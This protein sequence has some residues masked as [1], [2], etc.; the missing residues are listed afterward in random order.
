MDSRPIGVFDSGMGGLTS[1]APIMKK[2]PDEQI[3][4]YGDTARAPYGSKSPETVCDFTCQIAD[5]LVS[6]GTKMLVIAC[7]TI[8]A[9][10]IPRLAE[11][12]P[13][14]PVVGIIKPAAEYIATTCTPS[15][16]IGIIGTKVTVQSNAYP[17]A[18]SAYASGINI[19][20]LA[21]P[22]FVPLIEE[23]IIENEIMDLTIKHY[24]DSF[25]SKYNINKLVL[26]CTHYDFIKG[27]IRRLYPEL[28]IINPSEIVAQATLDALTA[29]DLLA[30]ERGGENI[31][32]AS[33]LSENFINFIAHITGTSD[34]KTALHKF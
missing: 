27:N 33:D 30:Q 8:S 6:K 11:S 10:A 26:G 34:F 15:D 18:V 7:N 19:H 13:N 22:P 12:F 14:I 23:G 32:C 1:I 21:C 20:A 24:L 29:A 4:Y 9:T 17:E 5:Y 16:S 31:Y 25:I 3:I 2:L 28:D